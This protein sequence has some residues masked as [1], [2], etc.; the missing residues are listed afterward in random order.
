MRFL[1]AKHEFGV[2]NTGSKQLPDYDLLLFAEEL[3]QILIKRAS[4]T[5]GRI[6]HYQTYVSFDVQNERANNYVW[7]LKAFYGVQDLKIT[8]PLLLTCVQFQI[9][10]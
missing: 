8:F 4:S 6:D 9:R 1:R 10:I 7:L 5:T 2:K 3:S